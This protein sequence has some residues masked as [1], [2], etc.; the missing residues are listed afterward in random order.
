M[1][2]VGEPSGALRDFSPWRRPRQED[3]NGTGD[4]HRPARVEPGGHESEQIPNA[5]KYNCS[6]DR[7]AWGGWG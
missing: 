2:H 1:A 3:F 4:V 6:T 5:K 7:D